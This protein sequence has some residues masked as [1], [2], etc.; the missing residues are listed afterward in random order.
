[1]ISPL[2]LA[3][4]TTTTGG[5][6]AQLAYLAAALAKRGH[7]VRLIYGEGLA[8]QPPKVIAGVECVDAAPDWRKPKGLAALA[9][10]IVGYGA[11]VTYARLPTDFLGIVGLLTHRTP[12]ARFMYA[13]ANDL[14]CDP[15]TAYDYRRW[16]HAPLFAL[17]LHSADIIAIQHESQRSLLGAPF[18]DKAAL[19]P[20][21]LR[22]MRATS[23]AYEAVD[24]D[25]I[26]IAKIRESKRLQIFIDVVT[27][28][29]E[30]RFAVVG[31][32]DPHAD[33]ALSAALVSRMA[34]LP[35]LE[36]LGPKQ[37]P[38]ITSLLCKSKVL[39]N[40]S[41]FEGFPNTMLEAWSVGVPVVSLV[42]DPGGVIATKRLG[43]VSGVR[44]KLRRDIL[45]LSQSPEL[46]RELGANGLAYVQSNHSLDA[47]CKALERA[48]GAHV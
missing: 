44:E 38:E 18:R 48:L 33:D 35:N 42:V 24:Y 21:L 47:L 26:W 4:D 41:D 39:V 12:G 1:M 45:M 28:M 30:Q 36:Y 6:E 15:W 10:S 43:L 8:N 13:I 32:F 40:T 34:Q 16:F 7:E 37:A 9:S 14:H 2:V 19:V 3:D 23:R 31:G 5:A 29:P 20:N 46:N 17:G 22:A 27:T 25:A 11:D